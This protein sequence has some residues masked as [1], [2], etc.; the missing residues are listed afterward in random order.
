MLGYSMTLLGSSAAS[1]LGGLF[2]LCS[3]ERES[4]HHHTVCASQKSLSHLGYLQA[5]GL[6]VLYQ[7]S[8]P[9]SAT[10]PDCCRHATPRPQILFTTCD[11]L[12]LTTHL[13][14]S[15]SQTTVSQATRVCFNVSFLDVRFTHI[16]CPTLEFSETCRATTTTIKIQKNKDFYHSKNFSHASFLSTPSSSPSNH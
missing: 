16:H 7:K 8:S 11:G 15:S 14:D 10:P 4:F 2:F 3:K 1:V 5:V 13:M 9:S 6:F 12:N